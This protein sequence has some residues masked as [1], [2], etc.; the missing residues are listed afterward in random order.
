MMN[1]RSRTNYRTSWLPW[2]SSQLAN[3]MV[4]VD[5]EWIEITTRQMRKRI[6]FDYGRNVEGLDE[7]L[8]MVREIRGRIGS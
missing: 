3:H 6:V 5:T 1:H 4:P 7:L 2:L 8:R